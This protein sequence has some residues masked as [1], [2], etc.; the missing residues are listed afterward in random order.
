MKNIWTSSEITCAMFCIRESNCQS[1]NFKSKS[2]DRDQS[3]TK[4]KKTPNCELNNARYMTHRNDFI[5][6]K[7]YFYYHIAYKWI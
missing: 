1:I 2:Q 3:A 4:G 5:A 7:G 6:H